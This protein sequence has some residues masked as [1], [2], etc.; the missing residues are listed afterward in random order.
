MIHIFVNALAASAGGGLTY[1]R[2]VAPLFA[3]HSQAR[4]TL[5]AEPVLA[6]EF[7][8]VPNL[9]CVEWRGPSGAASRCWSEQRRLPG[10]VRA[11]GAGVLLSAGNFALRNSPVP[12]VLLSRNSLY[13]SAAFRRD[14]RSRGEI[15]LWLD[16]AIKSA[17]AKWSI[18][19]ADR[20]VAPS[21][22]F[23][24][25]L[26]RWSGR[27]VTAIH[28]GFDREAFMRDPSPLPA[29]IQQQLDARCGELKLLFVSHYN[30]YRNFETL[31]RALPE[32]ARRLHP[33]RRSPRR[34]SPVPGR[35]PEASSPY[36]RRQ[37]V[38]AG[39]ECSAWSMP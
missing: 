6:R 10:L 1:V 36:R 9:D 2:N 34:Q 7:R 4:A 39:G 23:A 24:A 27:P 25:E 19:A 18:R 14:L 8:G 33:R 38:T 3:E 35:L 13:T 16:H 37:F 20:T 26:R 11:S 17:A 30:Y 29:A 22:A 5:L 12:Q 28:H 21:E 15:A 31:L 32:I